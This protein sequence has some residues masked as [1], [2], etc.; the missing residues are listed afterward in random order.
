[1]NIL[2]TGG[3]GFVGTWLCGALQPLGH[4]IRVVDIDGRKRPGKNLDFRVIDIL[5][6]DRLL[7]AMEGVDLV[8]HLAAKHRFFGVSESEF[9]RVNEAG[10]VSVLEAMAAHDVR[11]LIFYST[12]AVYGQTAGPAGEDTRLRPATPYG[13]SKLAAEKA[14]MGWADRGIERSAVILRPTV[15]F[16]P[17]NKGN[18]YRLIRQIRSRAFIP[19]GS[20][21]N[22]KSIAYIENMIDA[23]LFLMERAGNGLEIYNYSDTPH[24]AF[25]EIVTLIH[26][27]LGRKPPRHR[28]PLES[29][30][31]LSDAVDGILSGLHVEFSLA[32]AIEKMNKTTYYESEKIRG[33]GFHQKHSLQRGLD[34]MVK[35]YMRGASPVEDEVAYA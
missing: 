2:V 8:V 25:E 5:E 6:K 22:I 20:G 7:R 10:T 3:A 24:M 4:S 34:N 31:K 21:K 9:F 30:L 32:A 19:V 15:I 11:R 1:M 29:M 27:S 28:L 26:N 16:G 18:I 23:T 12:V 14:I 17:L 13:R 35:W 33:L